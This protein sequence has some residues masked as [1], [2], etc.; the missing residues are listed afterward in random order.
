MRYLGHLALA[1]AGGVKRGQ[2]SEPP[3]VR[4]A[5][6]Q[7]ADADCAV[8]VDPADADNQHTLAVVLAK[9][10]DLAE[11]THYLRRVVELK[12]GDAA[13]ANNLAVTLAKQNQFAEAAQRFEAAL[14]IDPN[15]AEAHAG[16]ARTLSALGKKDEA[17]RHY[18]EAV[19][20]LKSQGQNQSEGLSK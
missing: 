7:I 17:V 8:E 5:R 11:A 3:Q 14:R 19:R 15:F 9:R 2:Q 20:L 16:L 6:G 18:Q 12:P 10:G 13:A 1:Q 4:A